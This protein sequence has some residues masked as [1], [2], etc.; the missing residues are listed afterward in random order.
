MAGKLTDEQRAGGITSSDDPGGYDDR[1]RSLA[2]VLKDD[3]VF[4][5]L[6]RA[7]KSQEQSHGG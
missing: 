2:S 4:R 3:K 6:L 1:I 5:A 7:L